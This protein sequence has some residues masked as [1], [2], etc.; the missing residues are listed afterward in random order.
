M[1][2][3]MV[4][5]VAVTLVMTVI[6]VMMIPM[7][8]IVMIMTTSGLLFSMHLRMRRSFILEPEL[9]HS[10]AYNAPQ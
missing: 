9:G 7:A 8:V 10:I 5:V 4:M 6:M 2:V 3:A 1:A